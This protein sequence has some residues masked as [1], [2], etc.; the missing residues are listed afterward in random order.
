MGAGQSQSASA[1]SGVARGFFF[2]GGGG[3]NPPLKNV[4]KFSEDKIV[5]KNAE[6]CTCYIVIKQRYLLKQKLLT[7]SLINYFNAMVRARDNANTTPRN[8]PHSNDRAG[9]TDGHSTFLSTAVMS[10]D[11]NHGWVGRRY[12]LC[13]AAV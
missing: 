7:Y 2:F 9:P 10:K 1:C 13:S 11:V 5:E 8:N 4:K 12:S 3:S 6:V